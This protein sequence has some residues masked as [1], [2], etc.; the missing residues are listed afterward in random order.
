MGTLYCGDNLEILH[1]DW[2]GIDLTQLAL[3]LIRNRLQDTYGSRMKFVSGTTVVG[4]DAF[5]HVPDSKP[6][7]GDAVERVPTES[8]VRSIGEPTTSNEAATQRR[9][10]AIKPVNHQEMDTAT[11][12]CVFRSQSCPVLTILTNEERAHDR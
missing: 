7:D 3:S 12:V 6:R 5:H 8:I 2:T 9:N 11:S 1:R 10:T 4:R